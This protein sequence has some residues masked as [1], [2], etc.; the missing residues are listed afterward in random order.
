MAAAA[1][2]AALAV[3]ADGD[4]GGVVVFDVDAEEAEDEEDAEDAE[5]EDGVVALLLRRSSPRMP[6]GDTDN[7]PEGESPA[8]AKA[9]RWRT[10]CMRASCSGVFLGTCS[11]NS[12]SSVNSSCTLA[13]LGPPLW[14]PPPSS[15][16]PSRKAEKLVRNAGGLPFRLLLLSGLPD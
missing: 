16:G 11:S 9:S 4:G 10:I 13:G 7:G 6:P 14:P 12:I 3:A 2:A 1:A 5:D 8:R 15:P